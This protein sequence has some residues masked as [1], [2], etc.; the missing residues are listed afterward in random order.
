MRYDPDVHHRRSIRLKGYDYAEAGAYFVTICVQ[1]RE[2]LF[3]RVVDGAMVLSDAGR[4]VDETLRRLPGRFPGMALDA[5]VVMPNH[6]HGIVLILDGRGEPRVRPILE[7]RRGESCI[8]PNDQGDHKD[9]PYGTAQD[10][11]GRIV[12]AFKSLATMEYTH[13]VNQSGWPPFPGRL[14]QRNYYERVIRNDDELHRARKYIAENPM[15]WAED[16]ENPVNVL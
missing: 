11:L 14:W 10:S 3:G 2:C 1:G 9:R 12:Q 16:K 6:V 13:G 7:D 15:K 5:F 4:V 8:R